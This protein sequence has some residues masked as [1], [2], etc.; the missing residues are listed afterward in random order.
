MQEVLMSTSGFALLTT[1]RSESP[2][3]FRWR[4]N[5]L[6]AR[7]TTVGMSVEA[8]RRVSLG[9][10]VLSGSRSKRHFPSW[11]TRARTPSVPFDKAPSETISS[12]GCNCRIRVSSASRNFDCLEVSSSKKSYTTRPL[13]GSMAP[14]PKQTR[15]SAFGIE[16]S[17]CRARRGGASTSGFLGRLGCLVVDFR[18]VRMSVHFIVTSALVRIQLVACLFRRGWISKAVHFAE[19]SL[20]RAAFL[21]TRLACGLEGRRLALSHD[22]HLVTRVDEPPNMLQECYGRHGSDD[23]VTIYEMPNS[24]DIGHRHGVSPEE[25][26]LVADLNR[27][28][29]AEVPMTTPDLRHLLLQRCEELLTSRQLLLVRL[30]RLHAG[31]GRVFRLCRQARHMSGTAL[32]VAKAEAHARSPARIA[33]LCHGLGARLGGRLERASGLRRRHARGQDRVEI[34]RLHRLRRP[35]SRAAILIWLRGLRCSK[36]THFLQTSRDDPGEHGQ[37]H[38]DKCE[39]R[40]KPS[41]VLDSPSS[42]PQPRP[43]TP[44]RRRDATSCET[45]QRFRQRSETTWTASSLQRSEAKAAD[46]QILKAVELPGFWRENAAPLLVLLSLFGSRPVLQDRS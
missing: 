32:L 37:R 3:W 36:A 7:F 31:S 21:P 35:L 28:D 8:F 29:H 24:R 2:Y 45:L 19:R 22:S 17:V 10:N 4:C 11:V 46:A 33:R 43:E 14:R 25:S 44:R 9:E 1:T 40:S 18:R 26:E 5:A 38:A 13:A 30:R 12:A 34:D 23:I 41:R 27:K 39:R 16:A 6:R 20:E 15:L 42:A